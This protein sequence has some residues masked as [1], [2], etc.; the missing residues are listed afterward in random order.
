MV[1]KSSPI[2]Q[3][4]QN[5]KREE[6]SNRQANPKFDLCRAHPPEAGRVCVG[7]EASEFGDTW[8]TSVCVPFVLTFAMNRYPRLGS[9]SM[10]RGCFRFVAKRLA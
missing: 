9:V 1:G 2:T 3:L 8:R 10:Y 4:R 5:G 6:N 7:I